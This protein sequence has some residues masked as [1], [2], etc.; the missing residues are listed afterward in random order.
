MRNCVVFC[1]FV[2]LSVL[3]IFLLPNYKFYLVNRRERDSNETDDFYTRINVERPSQTYT[4]LQ[5]I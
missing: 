5:L 3:N 1:V 4:K 2:H